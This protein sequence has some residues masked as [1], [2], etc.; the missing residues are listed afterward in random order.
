VAD[1]STAILPKDLRDRQNLQTFN[2]VSSPAAAAGPGR[3]ISAALLVAR[4]ASA[5]H[6]DQPLFL[7]R[8][9]SRKGADAACGAL[10]AL[11]QALLDSDSADDIAATLREQYRQPFKPRRT[12]PGGRRKSAP[13]A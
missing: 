6:V 7:D 12:A 11:T 1:D 5:Q 8:L 4:A 3:P 13:E 2:V 10:I 9:R